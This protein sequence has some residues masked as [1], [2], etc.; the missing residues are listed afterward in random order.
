[1]ENLTLIIL[2]N[3]FNSVLV[4]GLPP[5]LS[6]AL[7][8]LFSLNSSYA[9]LIMTI[10]PVLLIISIYITCANN[11]FTMFQYVCEIQNPNNKIYNITDT[12]ASQSAFV[13][14]I[15]PFAIIALNGI[16]RYAI[17]VL[18][19]YDTSTMYVN[20]YVADTIVSFDWLLNPRFLFIA[21]LLMT[22]Y[23]AL[24]T[25]QKITY[26]INQ[27]VMYTMILSIAPLLR[28]SIDI[29]NIQNNASSSFA[30]DE[31]IERMT[32]GKSISN[33]EA[34]LHTLCPSQDTAIYAA[35]DDLQES[36]LQIAQRAVSRL[37]NPTLNV[38]NLKD[39]L[40]QDPSIRENLSKKLAQLDIAKLRYSK[41]S[42]YS[43][44]IADE[45][46]IVRSAIR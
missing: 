21:L 19:F 9:L 5:W 35:M 23:I 37:G 45:I 41:I 1:M 39:A 34:V 25:I 18:Y 6:F 31:I 7:T 44:A 43:D 38:E 32:S 40:T 27:F 8:T 29:Y 13:C 16:S 26:F 24:I 22:L 36:I 33:I 30:T 17:Q 20:Q 28:M 42:L 2:N 10:S 4:I 15:S 46:Q 11:A 14:C 12:V 3:I